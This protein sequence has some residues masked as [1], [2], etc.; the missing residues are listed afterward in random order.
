[1]EG[2]LKRNVEDGAKSV[3]VVNMASKERRMNNKVKVQIHL[4]ESD[5]RL[6]QV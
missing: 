3:L 1:V 6:L 5:E 2:R 4:L